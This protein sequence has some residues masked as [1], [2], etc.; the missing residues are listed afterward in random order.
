MAAGCVYKCVFSLVPAPGTVWTFL[1][2]TV[3]VAVMC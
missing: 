3:H 1:C 2:E